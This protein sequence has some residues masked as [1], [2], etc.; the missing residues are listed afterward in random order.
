MPNCTRDGSFREITDRLDQGAK[1]M[2]VI[3]WLGI[4]GIVLGIIKIGVDVWIR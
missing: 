4:V 1:K 3:F 2:N